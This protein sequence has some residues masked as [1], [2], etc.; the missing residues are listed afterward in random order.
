MSRPNLSHQVVLEE[1][2]HVSDGAG[3][4]STVWTAL[5]IHWAELRPGSGREVGENGLPLSRQPMRIVVRAAP[6]ANDRR[7]LPGQRFRQGA[8]LFAI[9]A[10]TELD[11][12]GRYLVCRCVEQVAT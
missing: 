7:P 11:N 8:R 6:V 1:A 10:V 2:Q 5:G 12:E 3:G 9:E 4:S